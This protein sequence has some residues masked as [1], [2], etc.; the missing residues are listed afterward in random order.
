[1]RAVVVSIAHHIPHAPWQ[2]AR[3]GQLSPQT[4][5]KSLREHQHTL[6]L[7]QHAPGTQGSWRS[8]SQTWHSCVFILPRPPAAKRPLKSGHAAISRQPCSTAQSLRLA[9]IMV[10]MLRAAGGGGVVVGRRVG[11]VV[12]R[13]PAGPAEASSRRSSMMPFQ[14]WRP[15][16]VQFASPQPP[17]PWVDRPSGQCTHMW[18]SG[19]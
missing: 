11:D 17:M 13:S 4:Q 1:M 18:S 8:Q 7:F 2:H 3:Q 12:V 6:S 15:A 5:Q 9:F 14:P 16:N 10:L 19:W